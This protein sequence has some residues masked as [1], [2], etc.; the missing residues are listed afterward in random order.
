LKKWVG[1]NAKLY[2]GGCFIEHPDF[3]TSK[4]EIGYFMRQKGKLP[5][6]TL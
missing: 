2:F 1:T 4:M 3:G 6:A 5:P